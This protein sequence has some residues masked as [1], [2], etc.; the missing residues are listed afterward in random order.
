[1]KE[2][3]KEGDALFSSD[4]Q[5]S[6]VPQQARRVGAQTQVFH[7]KLQAPCPMGCHSPAA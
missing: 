6:R 2:R 3:I 1:M 5:L 7:A 4:E